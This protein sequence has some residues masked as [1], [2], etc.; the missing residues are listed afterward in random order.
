MSQGHFTGEIERKRLPFA[1]SI[2]RARAS[3]PFHRVERVDPAA[4]AGPDRPATA[5]RLLRA[6]A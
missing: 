6:A 2:P 4:R 5:A 1:R 3:L